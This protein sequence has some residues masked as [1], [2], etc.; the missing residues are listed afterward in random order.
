VTTRT[1][2]HKS[3]TRPAWHRHILAA[4]CTAALALLASW[5]YSNTNPLAT[6][7]TSNLH[8]ATTAATAATTAQPTNRQDVPQT[9]PKPP[10][11]YQ[12]TIAPFLKDYCHDCHGPDEDNG[13]LRFDKYSSTDDITS[14]RKSWAKTL[15][16]LELGA[17]PP[18]DHDSQPDAKQRQI[19]VDYLGKILF[20]ID[21]N[22]AR[23]P[24]PVTIRRLNRA[25]YDNTI[26]DLLGVDFQPSKTFPSDDVGEGFDNI[27]DVLSVS[28]LL[29]EKYLDAAEQVADKAIIPIDP[30]ISRNRTFRGQTLNQNA[31]TNRRNDSFGLFSQGHVGTIVEFPADGD[32]VL[33]IHASA[34]QA[35]PDPARLRLSLNSIPVKTLDITSRNRNDRQDHDYKLKIKKG[36][37]PL[38]VAFINDYYQPKHA[39]PKLR[40]DRNA[41]IHSVQVIGPLEVRPEDLPKS[42][43]ELV[44]F[45][46]D[47][48]RSAIEA[49]IANLSPLMRRAYRRPVTNDEIQ[50]IARFVADSNKNGEPF[51]AAMQIGLQAVLVSPHFLFRVELG[52]PDTTTDNN[53]SLTDFEL[54]TRLSYFLWSSLPDDTLFR[55]AEQK[56]LN[57]PDVL[58][59]QVRRMLADPKA[60]ALVDN[61]ASQWLNLR[62]LDELTPDPKLFPE[63]NDQLREAMKQETQLFFAE[64][65]N[66]N[67]PIT[68]FLDG[69][70]TYVNQPL[71]KLYA[72]AGV[73]GDEMKRVELVGDRRAGVLTHASILTL[74]SNPDRTSPVKRGK[75]IMDNI[76][77]TPPPPPPP[78]VPELEQT[79]KTSPDVPLR[80]QLEIHRQN[81]SCAICHSQMDAL[82]FGFENFDAIG[83][84]RDTDGKHQVDSSGTLPG[85]QTFATPIE[86]I[87]ILGNR[88]DR[89]C[90]SLARKLLVYA[91]GRGLQF[92]DRCAVDK[93]V[94]DSRTQDYRFQALVVAIVLSDPFRMRPT[95]GTKP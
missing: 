54:A 68:R 35:G 66:K 29:I 7:S 37:Q 34:D 69:R 52:Q 17:M 38:R 46:P 28:P 13:G 88:K 11:P 81:A 75:W 94:A 22:L 5:I 12:A 44:R 92:N 77:D 50:P 87:K 48:D 30:F 89:F 93:L 15:Q 16:Y 25:E 71:A 58:A 80:K 65:L 63:F 86:L 95:Q 41:Y 43:R 82:G 40:G 9:T 73:T 53:S 42:H 51:E 27:G 14:N 74:T 2:T 23:D 90:Q 10:D 39:D 64:I 36:K 18:P 79:A 1:T 4:S 91:L 83:R 55:L 76:L 45:R 24:G 67:L 8:A 84:W 32:Y 47:S 56:R 85:N 19:V 49:A 72:I 3:T 62:I 6:N 61:F 59:R 26:R 20:D 31:G 33:R 70:F 60:R 78:D 57:R 21:C